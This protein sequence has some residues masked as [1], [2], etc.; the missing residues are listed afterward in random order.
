MPKRRG[1]SAPSR[2]GDSGGAALSD[3][4]GTGGGGI[5][6]SSVCRRASP[7][8]A[9]R[10]AVVGVCVLL[11]APTPMVDARRAVPTLGAGEEGNRGDGAAEVAA[12]AGAMDVR[13]PT[14]AAGPVVRIAG[15][16][17]RAAA[18]TVP[19][20]PAAAPVPGRGEGGTSTLEVRDSDLLGVAGVAGVAD[21]AGRPD[22]LG[23]R[24]GVV[25][26]LASREDD[27]EADAD[28]G[29]SVLFRGYCQLNSSQLSSEIRWGEERTAR[30]GCSTN[31]T[32]LGR[33]K[34]P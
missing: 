26:L 21:G 32:W 15:G 2:T 6:T 29:G 11:V 3:R 24:A 1:D 7:G 23:P 20:G 25:D 16:L 12:D 18:R 31:W 28:G 8:A 30:L 17:V 5:N 13:R 34:T 4:S 9:R 10:D 14:P 19:V 22:A 27:E 33:T